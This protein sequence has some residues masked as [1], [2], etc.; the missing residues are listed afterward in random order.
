MSS[1]AIAD[2]IL[3]AEKRGY[4]RVVEGEDPIIVPDV[5]VDRLRTWFE[6]NV[7]TYFGESAKVP[8]RDFLE[9]IARL[10]WENRTT[11]KKLETFLGDEKIG[12]VYQGILKSSE[13]LFLPP[14]QM[15]MVHVFL[16]QG[17]SCEEVVGL[18][19]VELEPLGIVL[20]CH[21]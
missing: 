14:F 20:S 11:L 3:A 12:K 6:E 9:K 16:G 8:K 7:T 19:N 2:F 17:K 5:T 13:L 21:S 15:C 4:V 10:L 18:V 1:F